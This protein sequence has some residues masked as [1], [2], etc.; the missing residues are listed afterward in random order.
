MKN[1]RIS[2]QEL[3][4]TRALACS[5]ARPRASHPAGR[6]DADR[7]GAG[8][9]HARAR[10]LPLL[11]ALALLAL[12]GCQPTS[13]DTITATVTITN[14]PAN[15]ATIANGADVRL[16]TNGNITI[17]ATQIASTN[18]TT[19]NASNLFNQVSLA[20]F[21]SMRPGWPGSTNIVTF[22]G[23]SPLALIVSAGYCTVTYVTNTAGTATF[24]QVPMG[25]FASTSRVYMAS[26]LIA[27]VD[28]NTTNAYGASS[29]ALINHVALSTPQTV[30]NKTITNSTFSGGTNL[31][32]VVS[33][34]PG[35]SGT[36]VALTNGNYSSPTLYNAQILNSQ[37]VQ[38]TTGA[39]NYVSVSNS[40]S[41]NTIN[42]TNG[43]VGQGY[44]IYGNSAI[45]LANI[46]MTFY[47]TNGLATDLF[48]IYHDYFNT[49]DFAV[50]SNGTVFV[51][52]LI[53]NAV[54]TNTITASTILTRFNNTA[55]ASGPNA[56]V[57]T[58]TNT[59][60]KLSGSAGAFTVNGIAGGLNDEIVYLENSTGQP[61]TIAQDSGSDPTPGNRIYNPGGADIVNT[62]NPGVFGF[63]YDSSV[64]HWKLFSING[65]QAVGG[66]GT[67][68]GTFIGSI[69]VGNATNTP[70]FTLVN[71]NWISGGIYTNLTGRNLEVLGNVV[72]TTAAVAGYSQMALQAPGS[73]TNYASVISA[74]GGLTGAMTNAMSPVIV[75]N[76]GTFTWTNTSSGAGDSSTTFGGQ[77][78]V[79]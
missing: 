72:L 77:Y 8:P 22:F 12:A 15:G 57:N 76:G 16:W 71:T 49:L 11:I 20:A 6:K 38:A 30:G 40:I 54:G 4:S 79:F 31:N 32:T 64:T 50:R 43:F 5:E 70:S 58:S 42:S 14:T 24:I 23:Q 9:L 68:S 59:W 44:A 25:N 78:I 7:E 41:V 55:M 36:V 2:N 69:I 28:A 73:V 29:P 13:A 62:N 33:N 35:I 60:V 48:E 51:R 46:P 10:V 17:P 47:G 74:I 63:K 53:V 66:S 61:I 37:V 3:G 19:L 34:S 18:T 39:F 65:A 26:Q 56:A 75:T 52:S 1:S 21:S 45:P 27:D 67:F